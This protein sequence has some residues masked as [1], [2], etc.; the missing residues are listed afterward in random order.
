MELVQ[1]VESSGLLAAPIVVAIRTTSKRI[2]LKQLVSGRIDDIR[3]F[4]K[5]PAIVSSA[6]DQQVV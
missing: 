1:L 2:A 5:Y 4:A 6:N 3:D